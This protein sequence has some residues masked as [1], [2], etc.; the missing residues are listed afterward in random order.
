M[1]GNLALMA[2]TSHSLVVL[3]GRNISNR[4]KEWEGVVPAAKDITTGPPESQQRERLH[5]CHGTSN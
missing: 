2:T 3:N 5:R 1:M 4:P